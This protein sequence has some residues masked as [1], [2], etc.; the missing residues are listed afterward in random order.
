MSSS[1]SASAVRD[2]VIF[3]A[4][5]G[6]GD[7]IGNDDYGY[8]SAWLDLGDHLETPD[9]RALDPSEAEDLI[10]ELGGRYVIAYWHASGQRD[11]VAFTDYQ[12]MKELWRE[13]SREF[14][15]REEASE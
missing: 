6:F 8:S 13:L 12:E 7:T 15:N 3:N 2:I 4:F 9:G 11:W 1:F 14:Y 10:D 5:N